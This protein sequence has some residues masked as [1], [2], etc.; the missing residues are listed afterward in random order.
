MKTI[1]GGN[2][3][4]FTRITKIIDD[5]LNLKSKFLLHMVEDSDTETLEI[6]GKLLEYIKTGITA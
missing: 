5:A 4:L 2:T 3:K 6:K 1:I